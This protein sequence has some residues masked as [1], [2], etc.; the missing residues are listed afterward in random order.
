MARKKKRARS[1]QPPPGLYDPALDAAQGAA[2]RGYAD[3][4]ADVN[5]DFG[6]GYS[7]GRVGHDYQLGREGLLRS[8]SRGDADLRQQ[9][10]RGYEDAKEALAGLGRNY[11]RLGRQQAEGA[12]AKGVLSGGLAA[13]SAQIRAG[14]MAW[15]R[16]PIDTGFNRLKED[17][18]TNYGRLHEDTSLGLGQLGLEYGRQVQDAQS[19]LY[20][21][22][23][24]N[25]QFGLD[26]NA[27][28]VFAATQAGWNPPDPRGEFDA[29]QRR[30]AAGE[31]A[32]LS[33]ARRGYKPR[34]R[35]RLRGTVMGQRTIA[36]SY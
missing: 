36:P 21:A 14:N 25:V 7:G 34:G 22:G 1:L 16:K 5:R 35:G 20:R 3:Y 13:R 28:R 32:D 10:S 12:R 26:T 19:G 15:D 30:M 2:Q 33:H 29:Y 17:V 31:R 23:R 27:S 18:K 8:Q 6:E 11:Q 9:Q 4:Q 24:E